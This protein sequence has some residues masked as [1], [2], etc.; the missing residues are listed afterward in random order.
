MLGATT[1][2]VEGDRIRE[3]S[4]AAVAPP[5][6]TQI[7]LTGQ[8]C[9]PGLIDSHTHLTL[10]F[11]RASYSETFHWNV[12]DYA[13]VQRCSHERLC[14]RGSLQYE[15]WVTWQMSPLPTHAINSGVVVGPRIFTAGRPIGSTGGHADPTNGY[16]DDLA[17]DPGPGTGV[18]NGVEDA[19]K[20]VASITSRT[21]MS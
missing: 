17:G 7:D 1:V 13:I 16:R 5:G 8:T 10:Q 6:A 20:A 19:V 2:L 12:A 3:V 21:T 9:L 4:G 15:T 11:T 14:W 18:I